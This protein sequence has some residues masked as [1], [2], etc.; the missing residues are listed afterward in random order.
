MS[1]G[2][3]GGVDGWHERYEPRN[4]LNTRKEDVRGEVWNER[5]GRG[6]SS[7]KTFSC[8][9]CISWL[10]KSEGRRI[11]RTDIMFFGIISACGS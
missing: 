4:T 3:K 9:S 7:L 6:A 10:T 5:Y 2:W 1:Q 11:M 8:A